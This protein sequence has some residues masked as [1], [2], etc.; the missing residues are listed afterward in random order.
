MQLRSYGELEEPKTIVKLSYFVS[1]GFG[2]G[3]G[4]DFVFHS[5]CFVFLSSTPFARLN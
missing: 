1:F 2:A 3:A 4:L 5:V